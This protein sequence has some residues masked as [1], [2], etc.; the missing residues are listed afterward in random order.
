[1]H[2]HDVGWRV[3]YQTKGDGRGP[4]LQQSHGVRGAMA[5]G[6]RGVAPLSE[7][8]SGTACALKG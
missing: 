7:P 8:L 1:M 4:H 6:E 3:E 2:G 5:W